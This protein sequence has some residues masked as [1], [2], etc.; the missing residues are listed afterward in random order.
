MRRTNKLKALAVAVL[1][2]TPCNSTRHSLTTYKLSKRREKLA[3]LALWTAE[4]SAHR[5]AIPWI[6]LM[7]VL[8][9]YVYSTQALKLIRY[10]AE[11][12]NID[13]VKRWANGEIVEVSEL[14]KF[15]EDVLGREVAE[16]IR[17]TVCEK[18]NL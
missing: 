2:L 18:L 10:N 1:I 11:K 9:L 6:N 14:L 12:Y 5:L 8:K 7:E 4:T 15:A 16:R 13:V 17:K 3:A